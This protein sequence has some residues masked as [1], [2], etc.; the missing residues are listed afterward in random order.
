MAT[1]HCGQRTEPGS[2]STL[3]AQRPW[4]P[5][6]QQLPTEEEARHNISTAPGGWAASRPRHV[7]ALVDPDVFAPRRLDLAGLS[8]GVRVPEPTRTKRTAT[9]MHACTAP[10]VPQLSALLTAHLDTR[11]TQGR[12]KGDTRVA[13]GRH[14][15]PSTWP[16]A[17]GRC[18]R[19]VG[20]AGRL[21]IGLP[22]M[23]AGPC[24]HALS[25]PQVK[26]VV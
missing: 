3:T 5:T 2:G 14:K 17:H 19:K 13:R 11:A 12:H 24:Q 21:S 8:E 22:C 25:P 9:S 20:P 15:D 16:H 26:A 7:L 6:S 23:G 1:W 4:C 18:E 10:W